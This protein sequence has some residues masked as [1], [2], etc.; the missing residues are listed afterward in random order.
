VQLP[1]RQRNDVAFELR[2]L[3]NEELQAKAEAAGRG[4]DAAMATELLQAFGRPAEV[5]ARYRPELTIIDPADGHRFMRMAVIGLVV[6]WALELLARVRQPVDHASGLLGM[7]GQWWA[8]S[9]AHSLWWLGAL[10][11]GFGMAASARRRQPQASKWQPRTVDRIQGGRAAMVLGIVGMLCGLLVLLDPHWVLDFFWGGRAAPAAYDALTYTDTFLRRPALWLFALVA[12]NIPLS[13]AVIAKGRWSPILR[14]MD[15]GL[16]LLT[17]AAMA[18]AILDG[19][20]VMASISDRTIKGLM[21]LIIAFTLISLG[22]K[23]YRRVRP[24]PDEG[25]QASR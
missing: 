17:C 2:A 10:V 23:A 7:M 18:W 21:V 24:T 12:L 13:I 11:V 19:P 6:L 8:S 4:A 16:S 25:M 15:T 1:R 9:V 22:I 14:R 20:I 5:A 3:L